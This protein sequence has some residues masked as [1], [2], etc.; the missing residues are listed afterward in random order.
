M[1]KISIPMI[2][3]LSSLFLSTCGSKTA[4]TISVEEL[5][6]TTH[7]TNE[8]GTKEVYMNQNLVSGDD[9]QVE[10]G[11]D[12][13][14]LIDSDK[15]LFADSGTHFALEATGSEGATQTK[16]NLFEGSVLSGIDNKLKDE[17][18]YEVTTPNATMAV[19]GTVFLVDV[20]KNSNGEYE[21]ELEV[22]EGSVACASVENGETITKIIGAGE[23]AH[24]T[25]TKPYG[26]Y[27][28]VYEGEDTT[29]IVAPGVKAY[30]VCSEGLLPVLDAETDFWIVKLTDYAD[31]WFSCRLTAQSN[32]YYTDYTLNEDGSHCVDMSYSFDGD[33]LTYHRVINEDGYEETI[34]LQK[35]GE[36]PV[37]KY[38]TLVSQYA[39]V[40]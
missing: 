10:T 8:F 13:T 24:F 5:N 28:G 39:I 15:H 16:I 4:R 36:D 38:N 33:T 31:P 23:E 7:V 19:R 12:M 25:G 40:E 2:V 14:L 22:A 18:T 37:E 6:G 21:T 1:R 27:Y 30:Q 20:S 26:Q 11:S 34:V 29:I 3:L 17:E 32:S 9:V 35:T